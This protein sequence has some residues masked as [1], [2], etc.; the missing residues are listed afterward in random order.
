MASIRKR[1]W[2][3]RA[4]DRKT[5]WIVNY[6][7]TAG[8]RRAKQFARRK[9]ADAFLTKVGWE[10]S[11]GTHTPD[12]QSITVAKAGENWIIRAQREDLETS[13][14][15]QYREHLKL[16]I[17]PLMGGRRLNQLTKPMIEEFRDKLLDQ[18]RSRAMAAKVLRSLSSMLKEAQRVGHV[19]Q[20]VAHGITV[21]RS[22]RDKAKIVPPTKEHMRALIAAA[23]KIRR[24]SVR[25]ADAIVAAFCWLA[26]VGDPSPALGE[27]RSTQGP[28]RDRPTRQPAKRYWTTEISF[29]L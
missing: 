26:L 13:T 5:A 21:R 10:V 25:P 11:Q 17:D 2:V 14:V 27:C 12:S 23:K 1:A 7:D 24:P 22:G 28:H 18:G 19:A 6:Q 8:K 15:K 20:N 4:G 3:S 16:H 9:D 29:G